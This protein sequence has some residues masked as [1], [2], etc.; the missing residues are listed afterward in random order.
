MKKIGLKTKQCKTLLT[1]LR[2]DDFNQYTFIGSTFNEKI[3]DK[4]ILIKL[5]KGTLFTLVTIPIPIPQ[6]KYIRFQLFWKSVYGIIIH[7]LSQ[8]AIQTGIGNKLHLVG[9]LA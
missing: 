1:F 5:V 3:R 2:F 4:M 7:K 9:A 8:T 6:F